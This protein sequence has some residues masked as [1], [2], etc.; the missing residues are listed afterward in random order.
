MDDH[1]GKVYRDKPDSSLRVAM[2]LLKSGQADAL[3]SAGNSG[4]VLSHALFLIGRLPGVARPG[5]ATAMPT[6][7]G[8]LTLCDAGANVEV[9]PAML[10]QF[11]LLA[12][13][14]DSA[15]HG[16]ARP[17]VGLLSNGAEA[18]KG[19]KLTRAAHELLAQ[20][21]ASLDN[22]DYRGYIEAS[23][24]FSGEVDVIA[25]DGFTGNIVLKLAEGVS[26]M[27]L[28]RVKE[29][30]ASSL[31][32]KIGAPLVGPALA[33]LRQE[34][35]Y[36]EAGGALLL[37]V[38]KLVVIAHGRSDE[39]AIKNAIKSGDRFAITHLIDAL[40]AIASHPH[41]IWR[42]GGPKEEDCD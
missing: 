12:A 28:H 5:I 17:R 13:H 4:A 7:S 31:R 35:H 23:A 24:M 14:Y 18:S 32:A 41:R 8:P 16:H 26:E 42:E 1:P 39:V 30:L 25:T 21:A 33:R 19:T 2:E 3:V 37:G 11:A 29:T 6:P 22:F 9:K 10:A 36:S 15:L 40:G 38:K 27:V 20:A 34:I